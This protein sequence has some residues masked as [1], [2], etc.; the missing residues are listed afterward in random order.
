MG[1]LENIVRGAGIGFALAL[2][3]IGSTLSSADYS[4]TGIGPSD[5]KNALP[6]ASN[7]AYSGIY[8]NPEKKL[9]DKGEYALRLLGSGIGAI[10]G[11]AM[12]VA[13]PVTLLAPKILGIY[14]G[15]ATGVKYI[16][17][18]TKG[19]NG[20][21]ASFGEGFKLG[22]EQYSSFL[23]IGHDVES[24]LS[25]RGQRNS[26]IKS[27]IQESAKKTKRN[28]A[29]V[30]GNICGKITGLLLSGITLGIVPIY[31]TLRDIPQVEK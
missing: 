20:K 31:K 11:L 24:Y 14:S 4:L 16:Q 6:T 10:G 1:A 29:S 22:Y 23:G 21:K 30:G 2:D 19:E 5:K 18:F 17:N 28:F 3:P 25:G 15:I 13:A 8:S 12:Y 27:P 9:A 26:H 7:L